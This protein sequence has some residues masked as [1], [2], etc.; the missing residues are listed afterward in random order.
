MPTKFQN[1]FNINYIFYRTASA[2]RAVFPYVYIDRSEKLM[3]MALTNLLLFA[4]SVIM[5]CI[6]LD[7]LI[8][9]I[10]LLISVLLTPI[11]IPSYDF[12]KYKSYYK[13]WKDEEYKD[14]NG[15]IISILYITS[16][17]LLY[18]AI[19]LYIGNALRIILS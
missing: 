12:S 17:I 19:K 1:P 4:E 16:F 15:L 18:I 9:L 6:H 14:V 3:S 5:R 8:G 7:E 2:F 10:I 11:F 13:K